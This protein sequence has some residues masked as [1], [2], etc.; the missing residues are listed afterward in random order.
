MRVTRNQHGEQV[1]Q[2]VSRTSNEVLYEMP[3]E[4]V[5]EYDRNLRQ[6]Q[7][8]QAELTDAGVTA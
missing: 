1:I 6:Q 7:E 8:K 4:S 3:P 2:V 5:L